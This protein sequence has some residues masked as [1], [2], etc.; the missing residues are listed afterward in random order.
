MKRSKRFVRMLWAPLIST[1]FM[2]TVTDLKA[3]GG[4]VEEGGRRVQ[5]GQEATPIDLTGYWTAVVTED[6][7]HRM[8]TPP[9]GDYL[10]VPLNEEA[11]RIADA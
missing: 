6:W 5:S 1:L 11:N 10:S 7:R 4:G 9:K 2:G 3:W 8:V